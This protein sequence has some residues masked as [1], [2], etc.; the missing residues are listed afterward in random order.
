MFGLHG[1]PEFVV[2]VGGQTYPALIDQPGNGIGPT[3]VFIQQRLHLLTRVRDG[4]QPLCRIV[5]ITHSFATGRDQCFELPR[6]GVLKLQRGA[7]LVAH[8]YQQPRLRRHFKGRSRVAVAVAGLPLVAL[9][10]PGQATRRIK[11]ERR[12]VCVACQHERVGGC[13]ELV[14]GIDSDPARLPCGPAKQRNFAI[15]KSNQGRTGRCT[16]QCQRNDMAVRP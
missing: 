12:S 9:Y 2:A 16:T 11:D 10:H 8:P 3:A 13:L 1:P 4:D 6:C 5:T 15:T 7:E 14:C